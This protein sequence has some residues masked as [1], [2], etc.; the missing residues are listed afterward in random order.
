[1]TMALNS[2][3]SLFGVGC[4]CPVIKDK[5][6][7]FRPLFYLG[8]DRRFLALCPRC[9][10]TVVVRNSKNHSVQLWVESQQ[11]SELKHMYR[12]YGI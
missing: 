7:S 1:M 4:F 9:E 2:M 6:N 5:K 11:G 12:M 3:A 10:T 8:T